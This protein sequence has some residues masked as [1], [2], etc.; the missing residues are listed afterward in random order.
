MRQVILDAAVELLTERGPHA[1]TATNV[2]EETGV[3][4]TTIY[5][6]WPDQAGL[7]LATIDTVVT[8]SYDASTT[9]DIVADV[10]QTLMNLQ[11]RLRVRPVDSVFAGLV[12]LASRDDDFVAAQQRFIAGLLQPVTDVLDAAQAAGALPADLDTGASTATLAGPLLH[13]SLIMRQPIEAELI[14]LLVAQ[15]GASIEDR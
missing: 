7:L 10:R 14:E 6:Q 13:Q 8:P 11:R 2:A 3:A 4:R 9:G 15:F 12:N 1:V 5:R